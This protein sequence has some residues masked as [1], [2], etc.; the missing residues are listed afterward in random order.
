MELRDAVNRVLLNTEEVI[1]E[2]ELTEVLLR[3]DVRG[4]IGF[5]PSGLIH[6]GWLIWARK[7][8]DLIDAGVEMF[9]LAAT[10]HAWINDK[11][12]G[13]M[14][15]IKDAARMTWHFLNAVGVNM[16]RVNFVDSEELVSDDKYWMLVLKVA[17]KLTLARV[18]RAIT[19]MGR[20]E[21]EANLDFSKLIY[22]C[23]QVA[24]IFYLN[25]DIALGG[26]D[27]RKAHVLAREIAPKLGYKKPIAI[28]TPLLIGLRGTETKGDIVE[29]K[30]SKS[31]PESCIFIHDEPKVIR[32]KIKKAYCPPRQVEGNPILEIN[33]LIL[34]SRE[35]FSLYIDRP[36]K[37]GGP[38]HIE[39]YEKLA[40]MYK[41]GKIHPL[42]LKEATARAL[43]EELK[44]IR[45]YIKENPEVNGILKRLEEIIERREI[46]LR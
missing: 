14:K 16:K 31:K 20:H 45:N 6:I 12:G 11:L 30:M 29:T 3:K 25:L 38:L 41:T 33:R 27:Q 17:K 34:F 18:K 42:D 43:A 10:W 8:Q 24:D 21:E 32:E 9:I 35:D 1:T 5:E 4:Y 39:S 19:I 22:P 40:E 28:H 15:L 23:M 26:I 46:K 2:K 13:D 7:V 44:P 36:A 37:Y